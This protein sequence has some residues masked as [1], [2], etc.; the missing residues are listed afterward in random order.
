MKGTFVSR[1]L[2]ILTVVASALA[3]A[4]CGGG[5]GNDTTGSASAPANGGGGSAPG[6]T[7]G[8]T[9]KVAADPSGALKFDSTSLTAKAGQ[10]TT[11]DFTNES[12]LSHNFTIEDKQGRTVGSTPTFTGGSKDFTVTLQPG[13]YTFLCTVPGHEQGG[14]KGTLT[15][16]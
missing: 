6:K 15:V 13:T 14:M 8:G 7:G 10:F 2:L 1:A 16:K 12:P 5:G 11:Y 9:V 3:L 4:A